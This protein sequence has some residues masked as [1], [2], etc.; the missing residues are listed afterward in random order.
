MRPI[1]Q[2]F[3]H[4]SASNSKHYDFPA[5]RLDHMS[6]GWSDIGYHFGIDY[7]GQ[8]HI[9]RPI[10]KPGAHA[11]GYNR[12]S[13]GICVLGLD[14]DKFTMQQFKKLAEITAMLMQMYKIPE[15]DV[16]PHNAVS[17]KLCPVFDFK[18]WKIN[19]LGPELCRYN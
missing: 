3:I 6:R 18:L 12:E 17:N 1:N 9:L 13:I 19:Y 8:L 16:L 15:D 7:E 14:E 2:I 5:I 4:C 10:T 11:K